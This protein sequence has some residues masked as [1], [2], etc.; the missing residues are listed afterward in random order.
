VALAAAGIYELTRGGADA[1]ALLAPG[2][3][4]LA[5]GLLAVRVLPRIA[6][7][8][9]SRTR[10]SARLAS[11]LASRNIARRP[12]GLRIVVLLSLAVGL[13]V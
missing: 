6:R 8:E 5:V 3:V 9:V 10:G 2:L 11:F 4:A 7:V 1:L 12:S 13:A